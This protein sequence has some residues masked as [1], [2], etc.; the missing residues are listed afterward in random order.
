MEGLRRI[1]G[2]GSVRSV[3]LAR[4]GLPWLVWTCTSGVVPTLGAVGL[5]WA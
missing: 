2:R 4:L 1:D 3:P 5:V